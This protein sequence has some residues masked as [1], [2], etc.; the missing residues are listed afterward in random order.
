MPKAARTPIHPACLCRAG[1][2]VL[3]AAIIHWNTGRLGRA[4]RKRISTGLETPEGLLKHISPLG[5][6][7]ILITGEY[8]WPGTDPMSWAHVN[9]L[10][11]YDFSD[12]KLR[13]ALGILPLK[14]VA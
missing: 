10:G 8:R 6:G 1:L 5:W 14:R 11:E 13:D 7:H 9:M 2:N 3:T 4:V 12:E